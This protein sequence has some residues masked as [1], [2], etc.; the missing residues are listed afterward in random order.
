MGAFKKFG[1]II[2]E[3]FV[4]SILLIASLLLVVPFVPM[5]ISIIGYFNKKREQRMF[6]DIYTTFKENY[7]IILKFSI[8]ELLLL[9]FS[10][11][12][13]YYFSVNYNNTYLFIIVISTIT[14]LMAL[15]FLVNAPMI[16]INMNV[17]LKQLLFNCF[18]LTFGGL[19]RTFLSM[20]L[21]IGAL[22]IF[23]YF[24]YIGPLLVYFLPFGVADMIKENMYKLKAKRLKTTVRELKEIENRDEFLEEDL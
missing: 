6:K 8:V 4:I 1:D 14:G 9:V 24:P 5:W 2:F 11:L 16:I 23:L 7:K 19:G 13:L 21:I 20:V 18:T 12:N 3:Y 17:S 10:V 22:I 15:L